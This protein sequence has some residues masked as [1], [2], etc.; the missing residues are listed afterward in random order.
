MGDY[1]P[2]TDDEIAQML[3]FLGLRSLDAL[4]DVVPAALRLAGGL[5]LDPGLAEPD[6]VAELESVAGRNRPIGRDLVCFAGAGAYDHEV[7]AVVRALAGRSEFVTAYTPYQ[8]EVAQGV[9]QA[10]F[11]Y[12]TM[13]A[14]LFGLP[15]AN[16]SLYDGAASLTEAC[17]LAVGATGRQGILLS[18]GVHPH[19]RAVATTMATG[20]GH[21]IAEVPLRDGRT[22]WD[23]ARPPAELAAVV[24]AQPSWLGTI[25]DLAAARAVADAHQAL[26]VVCADP[27][28]MGVLRPP[29][30]QGADVVA[31]EGQ[32]LG[33]RLSFGGPYLGLFA[34]A[35]EQV[36]RLPGRLVGETRDVDGTRG[37]VTTLRAREQDI[38]RERATSN[39]CTNQTLMAVT[40][41][42][43]L[44]WLGPT[45]LWDV[46]TR[47]AQGAHYAH[48]QLVQLP[49]VEAATT[50][51]FLREFAVATTPAAGVVLA[52]LADEGFLGGVAASALTDPAHDGSF[53]ADAARADHVVVVAVT[54]RRT[55]AEIDGFAAAFGKAAR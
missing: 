41:A 8:A 5:D 9:L 24:V 33:T 55:R 49:G 18:S 14:R 21:A 45:G 46:A 10:V 43:Q 4:F 23:H 38:R 35:R 13:V 29:G 50:A 28:A 1:L 26:L 30:A 15:V 11:E 12:Q 20:T 17:N 42:I 22:A 37:Y 6:V 3:A 44:S 32:A 54:E 34:C 48:H 40:A 31:G 52:R 7:P 39:V 51:P 47:C 36:R 53:G 2:H 16:A 19:W 27:I 25:E